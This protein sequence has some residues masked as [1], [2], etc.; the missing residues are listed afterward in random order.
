MAVSLEKATLG[1]PLLSTSLTAP[2]TKALP[3]LA[4]RSAF[5]LATAL[6]SRLV[7]EALNPATT[8]PSFIRV[9][10]YAATP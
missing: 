1:F 5:F 2:S 3:V 9:S 8:P 4:M 10:W 6:R 7:S